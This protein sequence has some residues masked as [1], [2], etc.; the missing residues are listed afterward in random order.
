VTGRFITLEGIEGVGKSTNTK[1]VADLIK[2]AG[3]DV[4]ITREPGG[5][6]LAERLRDIALHHD[7][8]PVPATAEL[9]I[10]FAARSLH[11]EN[12]IKPAIAAGRWVVCD[13]FTDATYAYQGGGRGQDGERISALERWVQSGTQPDLTILLDAD[14]TIGMT[15]AA[16]RS[17]A[18][19]FERER[20]EFF[21]RVRLTYLARAERYTSRFRV[22]DAGRS[23]DRVQEDI[24]NVINK[25]L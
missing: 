13:R 3:H 17:A 1:F 25:E 19:R 15:R 14:P 7:D 22:I 23:L 12:L 24:R 18:D 4:I 5:T 9:L 10:M 8:E 16:E 11:L 6:P 21:Q 2:A 20:E